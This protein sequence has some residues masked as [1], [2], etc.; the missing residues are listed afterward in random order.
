MAVTDVSAFVGPYPFRP[1]AHGSPDWLLGQMDRL[2]IDAAWVG[3]LPSFLSKDPAGDNRALVGLVAPHSN[4]LIP[5]PTL[6]PAHPGCRSEL[7]RATESGAPAV[8]MYPQYQ[9]LAADGA[10]M[11]E[12]VAAA[13]ALG[14]PVILTVRF[15][16]QRQR[17]LADSAPEFPPWAVRALAR[18]EPQVRLLITNAHR[19]YIEEV[20]FGLTPE[21]ASRVLWD[22]SWIWGPPEGHLE[23]LL[24]TVGAERFTLGTGMPLRV[25]DAAVA[26]LDLLDD[27]PLR[28]A[29]LGQNL[30]RWREL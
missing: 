18:S 27:A 12:A 17:Q 15:E 19:A 6:N 7:A 1:V 3:H 14:L 13:A 23:L 29:V 9:D 21:E 24:E 22:I 20:H 26:K 4:R 16:D 2:G 28:A 11:R 8:R 30:G 25:P 5:V 10:Q